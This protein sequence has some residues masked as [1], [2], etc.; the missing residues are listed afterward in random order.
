[1]LLN[2]EQINRGRNS[3]RYRVVFSGI[4]ALIL[5]VGLA[6]FSYT[7]MLPIMHREA[8]L[9]Y[10]AGGWLA[11]FNYMGYMAGLFE[12]NTSRNWVCIL[13]AVGIVSLILSL[14]GRAYPGNPGKAMAGLTL[15]YGVAQ[16]T[17]PAMAGYIAAATGSYR[18]AL[19]VATAV[20]V[21]GMMLLQQL[22]RQ[23]R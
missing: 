16:I 18:G 3:Q 8:G 23:E 14:I 22:S 7:P 19:M 21:V 11:T 2:T 5:T 15:S 12:M 20:M 10:L 4:C 6:R 17:A 9:T 1:M 13:T